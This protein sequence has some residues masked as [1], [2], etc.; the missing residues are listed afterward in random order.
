MVGEHEL[1]V[2]VKYS[3]ES[4]DAA[5]FRLATLRLKV[6]VKP[7]LDVGFLVK[8]SI[9]RGRLRDS[10]ISTSVTNRAA[11]LPPAE[12]VQVRRHRRPC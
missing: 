4:G 6:A 7:L 3:A 8:P 1:V 9:G 10:I 2:L 5:P 12:L 11:H